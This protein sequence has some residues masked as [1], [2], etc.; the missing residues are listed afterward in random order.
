MTENIKFEAEITDTFGGEANYSWVHR[1]T[2]EAPKDASTSL[3]VR[4]AKR[5]LGYGGR[6]DTE[7]F[8]ETIQHK[9][10]GVCWVM[11]INPVIEE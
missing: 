1:E 5:A 6:G 7:D 4:R 2:F 11:F 9:F 10:R 3:L 8:G